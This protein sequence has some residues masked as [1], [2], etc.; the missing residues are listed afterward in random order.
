MAWNEHDLLSQSARTRHTRELIER[1]NRITNALEDTH[2]VR[3]VQ[4][5]VQDAIDIKISDGEITQAQRLLIRY[6]HQ[7]I[8]DAPEYG[9]TTRM[10]A[11]RQNV[12]TD[13][14][15]W[16]RHSHEHLSNQGTYTHD[17]EH[18]HDA[19]HGHDA[20]RAT[21]W[22]DHHEHEDDH[23][24]IE[25]E[26]AKMARSALAAR[27][28]APRQFQGPVQTRARQDRIRNEANAAWGIK[29]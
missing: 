18:E 25:A 21:R 2:F 1:G 24:T 9:R 15:A 23:E 8:D 11:G 26:Q 20:H 16:H 12:T 7:L 5:E 3:R 6:L 27:A 19:D 14:E 29:D 13:T 10:A 17:H 28:A 22:A 4:R